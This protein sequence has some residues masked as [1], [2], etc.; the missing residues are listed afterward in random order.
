MAMTG[1]MNK[2]QLYTAMSRTTKFQ[3]L[4]V[5]N[6]K[7]KYTY[8]AE[9]KHEVRSIGHTEY[10]NGKIYKTEFDDGSIYIGSTIKILDNRMK[11]HLSDK[12]SIV[13]RNKD[14]YPTTSSIIDCPCENKHK[15][16]LVEKKYINQ[17]AKKYGA[18]VLNKRGNEENKENPEIKYSFKIK[19]GDELLERIEKMVA[20]KNVPNNKKEL[21]IPYR[22]GGKK[23]MCPKDTVV[24]RYPK[25]WTV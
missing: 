18:E 13:Y 10:Q 3:Y 17:Y 9:N 20:I 15:L 14:K 24:F 8:N 7:Q 4:H 1:A 6:L 16:E 22:D 11:E 12:K 21:Q 2:K 5:E 25:Q 19:K 23:S